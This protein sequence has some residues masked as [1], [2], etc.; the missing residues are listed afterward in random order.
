MGL[1]I[2]PLKDLRCRL[3]LST[4][5][6]NT[7]ATRS[8]SSLES[9]SPKSLDQAGIQLVHPHI[10]GQLLLLPGTFILLHSASLDFSP[11]G[12]SCPHLRLFPLILLPLSTPCPTPGPFVGD[13]PYPG[14]RR[15]LG[16]Q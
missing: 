4:H 13:T 12:P 2:V 15:D 3:I 5:S 6:L 16:S 11:L 14:A 7:P 1:K 10:T 9:P 8:V